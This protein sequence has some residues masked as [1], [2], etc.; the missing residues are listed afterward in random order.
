MTTDQLLAY[1]AA[2]DARRC[3]K[4]EKYDAFLEG[5]ARGKAEGKA[6]GIAEGELKKA[7]EL[8]KKLLKKKIP[9]DEVAELT[10]LSVEELAKL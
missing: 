2:E 9:L 3:E 7:R 10:G 5:E 8:A 6:E 4:S 1:E